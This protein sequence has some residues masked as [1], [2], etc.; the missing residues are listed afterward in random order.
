MGVP[1][2]IPREDFF[3]LMWFSAL[4]RGA[5]FWRG[6]PHSV[7]ASSH[8]STG[9]FAAFGGL[10]DP[11]SREISECQRLTRSPLPVC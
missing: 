1:S 3:C 6:C 11:W 9:I 4:S 2:Q 8:P 10:N 5:S 7:E